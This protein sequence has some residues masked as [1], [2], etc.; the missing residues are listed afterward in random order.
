M[1]AYHL[2]GKI[3]LAYIADRMLHLTS[4]PKQFPLPT[5]A[6]GWYK[7]VLC[8]AMF[9]CISLVAMAQ[10]DSTQPNTPPP[11]K[12]DRIYL[13][14]GSFLDGRLK[15]MEHGQF[16]FKADKLTTVNIDKKNIATLVTPLNPL[17]VDMINGNVYY[18][19]FEALPN[20]GTA[21][22]KTDETDS[23]FAGGRALNLLDI[24][25]IRVINPNFFKNLQGEVAFGLSYNR[26]S[27]ILR[28]NVSNSLMYNLHRTSFVQTS[29]GI[30]TLS[31]TTA[32]WERLNAAIMVIYKMKKNWRAAAILEYQRMLELGISSRIM[33]T[34]IIGYPVI[35]TARVNMLTLSGISLSKEFRTDKTQSNIQWEWPIQLRLEVFEMSSNDFTVTSATTFYKGITVSDRIRVDHSTVLG[36]SVYK[37]LKVNLEF[38]INYDT[39]PTAVNVS[40]ADYGTVL[41]LGY[42]F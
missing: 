6:Q 31:D 13:V 19:R 23:S 7:L 4:I 9:C 33:N 35:H 36:I 30:N 11:K 5:P 8:I 41:G 2:D 14:N 24:E 16:T 39:R 32:S 15:K 17:R 10:A 40:H 38:F 37:D 25:T 21:F 3:P 42:T 26:S 34:E 27:N 22:I 18:G 1:S 29:N 20:N 12:R 28:T